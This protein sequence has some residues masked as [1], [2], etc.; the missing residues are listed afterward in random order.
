MDHPTL[1]ELAIF[2]IE[3]IGRAKEIIE[4]MLDEHDYDR[5]ISADNP[6]WL[7]MEDSCEICN[8]TLKEIFVNMY[9]TLHDVLDTLNR[10]HNEDD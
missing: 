4:T 10:R 3:Q 7:E 8:E 6:I 1:L 2:K 5:L 9:L